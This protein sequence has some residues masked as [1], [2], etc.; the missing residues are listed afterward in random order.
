[1]TDTTIIEMFA[2][3]DEKIEE[4]FNSIESKVDSMCGY[5]KGVV[6][7]NEVTI[8]PRSLRC[9]NW[10]CQGHQHAV[11]QQYIVGKDISAQMHGIRKHERIQQLHQPSRDSLRRVE[12]GDDRGGRELRQQ[13]ERSFDLPD[14]F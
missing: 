2:K 14:Y 11:L 12:P 4:R 9:H 6:E 3:R 10:R 8:F 13:V 1:M 5:L 7:S